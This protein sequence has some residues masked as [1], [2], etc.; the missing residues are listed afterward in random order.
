MMRMRTWSLRATKSSFGSRS[1]EV[2]QRLALLALRALDVA[3]HPVVVRARD[4]AAI[5]QLDAQ[6]LAREVRLGEDRDALP[7]QEALADA[8]AR[9]GEGSAVARS[10]EIQ[11]QPGK[12]D[13]L[14]TTVLGKA[15]IASA[16]RAF[17]GPDLTGCAASERAGAAPRRSGR[18]PRSPRA[19]P[20]AC[21]R[22][23]RSRSATTPS[24]S[25]ETPA[26][27]VSAPQCLDALDDLLEGRRRRRPRRSI[28]AG[29]VDHDHRDV[30]GPGVAPDQLDGAS[31]PRRGSRRG[32]PSPG[33]RCGSPARF[34][35]DAVLP[36]RGGLRALAR[37]ARAAR[38]RGGRRAAAAPRLCCRPPARP[39]PRAPRS[40]RRRRPRRCSWSRAP[41]CSRRGSRRASP[42]CSRRSASS[43]PCGTSP[44][45]ASCAAASFRSGQQPSSSMAPWGCARG[46]GRKRIASGEGAS[47]GVACRGPSSAESATRAAS[48]RPCRKPICSSVDRG[49]L[50]A[51]ARAS[52][53]ACSAARKRGSSRTPGSRASTAFGSKP[54]AARAREP[55]SASPDRHVSPR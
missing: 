3:D 24:E 40:G 1:F 2:E 6:A 41:G 32:P 52:S 31:G 11:Q 39:R 7:E 23:C 21:T 37:P 47:S 38:R 22:G 18:P 46:F 17:A 44:L 35:V 55:R 5:H 8:V 34:G 26:K 13:L 12:R 20:C 42:R 16:F 27:I 50:A 45:S 14:E 19:G 25:G 51:R 4:P 49:V 53:S 36:A 29:E 10:I 48:C 54:S 43:R 9:E 33:P 30:G 15:T 28:G